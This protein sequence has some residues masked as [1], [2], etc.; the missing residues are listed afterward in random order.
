MLLSTINWCN[1]GSNN[2]FT[3]I[4]IYYGLSNYIN[5]TNVNFFFVQMLESSDLKHRKVKHFGYEFQ[6]NSNR[7]DPD[8][9]VT[10]IPKNYQFLKTLFKK[11]HDVP[12]EYDQL[13]INH[14]LPGQGIFHKNYP[15]IINFFL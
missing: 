13:T 15:L 4:R 11:Y 3:F 10:P 6:Y 12:Y 7:V 2:F 1:E 5:S 9:P 14:Y 8:K